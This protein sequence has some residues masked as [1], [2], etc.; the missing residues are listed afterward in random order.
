MDCKYYIEMLLATGF[1]KN[2][3]PDIFMSDLKRF[4]KHCGKECISC[5]LVQQKSFDSTRYFDLSK[6]KTSLKM[7]LMFYKFIK[8][9]ELDAELN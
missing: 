9:W 5:K 3:N 7:D 4:E 2:T 1:H 8:P 6:L